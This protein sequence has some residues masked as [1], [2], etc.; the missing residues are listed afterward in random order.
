MEPESSTGVKHVGSSNE[1]RG[2]DS[3]RGKKHSR[4][5]KMKKLA[6]KKSNLSAKLQALAADA[7]NDL[8]RSKKD[9]TTGD[10]QDKSSSD[11]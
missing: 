6:S 2:L 7:A 9:K 4:K 10:G 11:P 8:E 1:V 5:F 3:G